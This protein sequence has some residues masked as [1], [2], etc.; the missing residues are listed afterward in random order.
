MLGLYE[1]KQLLDE[2][3]VDYHLTAQ[4]YRNCEYCL[5]KHMFNFNKNMGALKGENLNLKH[6][7]S[8]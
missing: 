6:T 7:K 1:L 5:F 4:N 8:H 2:N 3:E